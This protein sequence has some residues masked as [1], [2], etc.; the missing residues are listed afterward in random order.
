MLNLDIDRLVYLIGGWRDQLHRARSA[1]R[2]LALT[3]AATHLRTGND[4]VMPQ[5]IARGSEIER[6]EAVAH[7]NDAEFREIVLMAG[8]EQSL[9]RVAYRTANHQQN[10]DLDLDRLVDR[11]GGQALRAQLYDQL[12]VFLLTRPH[13]VT[14]D[15]SGDGRPEPDCSA[16]G[17]GS[18]PGRGDE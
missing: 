9:E 3:V 7:D 8:K 15:T 18:E 13:C 17:A 1:A 4:V 2:R 14:I 11:D 5:L 16:A 10:R 6:F 12:A